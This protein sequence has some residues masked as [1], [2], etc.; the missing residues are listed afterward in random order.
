MWSVTEAAS[1]MGMSGQ[2]VRKLLAED[3]IKGR[4][5]G[6]TWIIFELSYTRKKRRTK[7]GTLYTEAK[8]NNA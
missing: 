4:K 6:N 2:R 5:V 1:L 8:V 7:N 3:R